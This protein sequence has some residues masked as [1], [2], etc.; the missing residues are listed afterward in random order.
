MN[1][2]N[3]SLKTRLRNDETLTGIFVNEFRSPNLGLLLDQA[4]YDFAIYCMEHCTFNTH[5]LL[6]IVPGYRGCRCK[7]IVRVPMV[8]R[9]FFQPVLDCGVNGLMVPMVE[10]AAQIAE[11]VQLMK[12]PPVGRRGLTFCAPHTWYAVPDQKTYTQ[13]ANDHLLLVAQIETRRGL[14][15]LEE[16]LAVPGVDVVFVGN[17]DLSQ[18]LGVENDLSAGPIA[19]AVRRVFRVAKSFGVVGGGNFLDP[20]LVSEYYPEGLRFVTLDSEI[21]RLA[22]GLRSGIQA[23]QR[24][25]KG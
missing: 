3:D 10:S 11:A 20:A 21:E 8:S 6:H 13:A 22:A 18:S 4:G 17:T 24:G 1:Y 14:E 25:R 16:I 2:F 5:D 23:V 15:N 19:D 9:E 12:Y 7:P